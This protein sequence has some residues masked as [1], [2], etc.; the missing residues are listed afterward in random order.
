M[1]GLIHLPHYWFVSNPTVKHF[2][3]RQG[4][5]FASSFLFLTLTVF[6]YLSLTFLLR[7]LSFPPLSPSILR[8]ISA[9]HNLI[10]L[11]L[12]SSM[13]IGISLSSLSQMQNPKWLLCFPKS[14]T[15]TG[16]VF[17]WAYIFY[18][19]KILEFID[20][21]LIILAG[22]DRRLS[23]LHVYHHAVVIVM[24]YVWLS[25]V[26]SLMPI[27]LATNAC[28]HVIMYGYYFCCAIGRRPRWKRAVTDCQIV[29]FGLSFAISI[30]MVYYHLSGDGCSGIWGWCFNAVFNA[31]LLALF[32]DFHSKNYARK[33]KMMIMDK[34]S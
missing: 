9:V 12:S 30:V 19:S 17:F 14:Q 20:T 1:E 8:P 18:L 27:A 22:S 25:T 10:L 28:V 24:C 11:L 15:P 21:L 3:W 4:E 26:Q 6:T 16:P 7:R 32:M 33:K 34:L 5:T 13:A 2:Q 29:Q 23:F 31:S